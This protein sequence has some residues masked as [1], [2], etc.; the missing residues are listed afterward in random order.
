[1]KVKVLCL[2]S[3]ACLLVSSVLDTALRA[4]VLA[5]KCQNFYL[6]SDCS[7]RPVVELSQL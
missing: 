6:A 5:N 3:F 7:K 4:K 1:M 2:L